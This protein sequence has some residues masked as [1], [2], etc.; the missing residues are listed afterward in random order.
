MSIK[1]LTNNNKDID[2]INAI[3]KLA[4]PYNHHNYVN[5]TNFP[6]KCQI[7]EFHPNKFIKGGK[8]KKRK[9]MKNKSKKRKGGVNN[10]DLLKEYE[11]YKINKDKVTE[12]DYKNELKN[13]FGVE[14]GEF[15][16]DKKTPY[17]IY[18]VPIKDE[19]DARIKCAAKQEDN[20]NIKDD[21]ELFN[22]RYIN[23]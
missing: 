13:A 14:N 4:S 2:Y 23:I 9:N 16:F 3:N 10:K 18:K 7:Y 17:Y 20:Y 11:K 22:Y 1:Y 8:T 21:T 15:H 19:H 6:S 12:D 5:N